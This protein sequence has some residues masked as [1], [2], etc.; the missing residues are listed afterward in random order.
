MSNERDFS[1]ERLKALR[2]KNKY[3]S[4]QLA[5]KVGVHKS[6]ISA[7]EVGKRKPSL[8][9]LTKLAVAL[10]TT[11]D[12]LTMMRDD[13]NPYIPNEELDSV[14]KEKKITYKGKELTPEQAQKIAEMI[15]VLI[16]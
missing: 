6:S 1:K 4:T 5:D 14:L 7:F 12:Y 2:E 15:D 16:K 13:P 11:T 3:S 9:V 8:H 10:N